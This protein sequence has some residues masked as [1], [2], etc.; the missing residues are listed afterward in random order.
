MDRYNISYTDLADAG[1]TNR[2]HELIACPLLF[3][4]GIID[5]LVVLIFHFHNLKD[6]LV[7]LIYFGCFS[8]IPVICYFLARKQLMLQ[9]KK[10]I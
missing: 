7:S 8:I 10:H 6:Y 9:E 3:L 1:E 2:I 4:F 5:V